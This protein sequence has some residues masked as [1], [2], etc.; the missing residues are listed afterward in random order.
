MS[1][2]TNKLLI[3]S[4]FEAWN[5]GGTEWIKQFTA[6]TFCGYAPTGDIAGIDGYIAY[7]EALHTAFPD[8]KLTLDDLVA[9]GDT[10]VARYTF[11][12][13][14]TGPLLTLPAV[15]GK[16]TTFAGITVF[17][18]ADGKIVATWN[19]FDRYRMLQ[20]LGIVQLAAARELAAVS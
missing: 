15:T 19:S 18:I 12:G 3:Q 4:G 16:S 11:T 1:V 17:K 10:V 9:E 20:Q 14:N 2:E 8:M 7:F 13:T 6:P 5:T